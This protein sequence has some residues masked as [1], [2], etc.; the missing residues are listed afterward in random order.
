MIPISPIF[1]PNCL[2]SLPLCFSVQVMFLITSADKSSFIKNL[3]CW[4][5]HENAFGSMKYCKEKLHVQFYI[6]LKYK[7]WW[8][9]GNIFL[10]ILWFSNLQ[11]M[12]CGRWE[13]ILARPLSCLHNMCWIRASPILFQ[14]QND[15]H[16][17]LMVFLGRFKGSP[18]LG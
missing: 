2:L 8:L 17:F 18:V 4:E 14:A 13:R 15:L 16:H 1:A 12:Y 10:L 7:T 3:K 9:K 11:N 5:S 6:F